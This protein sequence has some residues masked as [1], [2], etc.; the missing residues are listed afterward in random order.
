MAFPLPDGKETTCFQ[1][2]IIFFF[3]ICSVF[4]PFIVSR[5]K[6]TLTGQLRKIVP[7]PEPLFSQGLDLSDFTWLAWPLHVD[8]GTRRTRLRTQGGRNSTIKAGRVLHQKLPP[9]PIVPVM[10]HPQHSYLVNFMKF[11]FLL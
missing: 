10:R 8:T 6:L 3:P 7:I 9:L 5:P 2:S 1:F 4:P 11:T